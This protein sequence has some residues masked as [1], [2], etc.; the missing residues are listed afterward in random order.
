MST[1]A[2]SIHMLSHQALQDFSMEIF[3]IFRH[4]INRM[5][6]YQILVTSFH[7]QGCVKE[8][9]TKFAC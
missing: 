6:T 8:E 9:A 3:V 7:F 1:K 4:I 5:E 2:V